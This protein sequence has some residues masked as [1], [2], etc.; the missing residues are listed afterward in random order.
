[1][2]SVPS[3]DREAG[4]RQFLH[5]LF[6]Q[7]ETDVAAGLKLRMA[8]DRAR[9]H[10]RC[11]H[12]KNGRL[13]EASMYRLLTLWKRRRSPESL[14]RQ[15]KGPPRRLPLQLVLEFINRLDSDGTF[16]AAFAL[17]SM[18]TSWERGESL[19][20]VGTWRD[21]A[22]RQ[23]GGRGAKRMQPP[24]FPWS[25][26]SFYAFLSG[27]RGREFQH[28]ATSALGARYELQRFADFLGARRLEIE[29]LISHEP[30]GSLREN[31][32]TSTL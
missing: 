25:K 11:R 24:R 4:R 16:S 18:R 29:R 14:S 28:R 13:S 7:I 12:I 21:Y 10:R 17:R 32:S 2:N 20:G 5:K 8:I 15:F 26:S 30:I 3:N 6:C 23:W 19:P 22:R 1:M 31:S 27:C 9:R